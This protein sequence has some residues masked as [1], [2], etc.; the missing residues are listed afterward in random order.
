VG[1]LQGRLTN[2]AI[3]VAIIHSRALL[4]F[5]GLKGNGQTKLKELINRMPGDTGIEQFSGLTKVSIK[6]AVKPYQ[7]SSDEAE[8]AFAYVVYLANKGLAHTDEFFNKH[9]RGT[10]LLEIALRGVPTL[11]INSFYI[12]LNIEPP[13][14]QPPSRVRPAD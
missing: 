1:V 14:Y 5:L 10:S 7:G 2:G 4:E 12:P 11:V 8:A 9:A 6:N 13:E 3:E